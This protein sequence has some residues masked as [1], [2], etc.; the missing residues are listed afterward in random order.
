MHDGHTTSLD[1]KSSR[2]TLKQR[3]VPAKCTRSAH[4][5]RPEQTSYPMCGEDTLTTRSCQFPNIT[6]QAHHVPLVRIWCTTAGIE[7]V[8]CLG[9]EFH[10][11]TLIVELTR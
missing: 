1:E 6:Q 4:A 3:V 11:E 5:V 10:I 2:T 9:V 7:L 8:R